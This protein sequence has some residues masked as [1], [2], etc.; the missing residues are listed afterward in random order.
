MHPL[1]IDIRDEGHVPDLPAF[2]DAFGDLLPLLHELA[3]TPQDPVWHAE[4]DV[5]IHTQMVLDETR[6]LLAGRA[7]HLDPERRLTLVLAAALHDIAKPLT[8]TTKL[9]R[10]QRHVVAPRHAERGRSWLAWRLLD[11]GLPYPVLT[12]LLATIGHHHDPKLLVIKDKPAPAWRRLARLADMELLYLLEQADMRGRRCDDRDEQIELIDLF[13]IGAEGYGLY[14]STDP[15]RTWR[16]HLRDALADEHPDLTHLVVGQAIRDHEAGLIHTPEEAIA[17]AWPQ[18]QGFP[19]LVVLCG[20]PAAG[21]TTWRDTHLPD[22]TPI[23]LDDLRASITG[24]PANQSR[25]DA[26]HRAATARLKAALRRG[27]SVVWDATNL[28]R[29]FRDAVTGLGFAYN[30][31]VTLVTFHVPL[32]LARARNAQRERHVPEPLLERL[33]DQWQWPTDD[34]AH[35]HLRVDHNGNT[36]NSS[37]L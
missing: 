19:R 30:A 10:G 4:G 33:F 11:L 18:R 8:T 25:N 22:H 28:R 5:H 34:E 24:D 7:A 14:P 27:E 17:R 21:K 1:L 37:M 6:A 9:I 32:D 3:D 29:D 16:E 35:R 23:C 36:L 31:L 12:R 20:P 2:I 26:V 13:R 15:Y